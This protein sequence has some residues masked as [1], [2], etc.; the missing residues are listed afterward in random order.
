MGALSEGRRVQHSWSVYSIYRSQRWA[1]TLTSWSNTR[2]SI[3][4]SERSYFFEKRMAKIV[5]S[6]AIFVDRW[7]SWSLGI[8]FYTFNEKK[9]HALYLDFCLRFWLLAVWPMSIWTWETA[10]VRGRGGASLANWELNGPWLLECFPHSDR[11]SETTNW[12]N[13]YQN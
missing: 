5:P 2:P 9:H 10:Q 13:F 11:D 6:I 4:R 7:R 12:G 1:S 8:D 3:K